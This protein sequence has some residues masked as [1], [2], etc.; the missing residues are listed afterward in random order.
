MHRRF[1]RLTS[2]TAAIDMKCWRFVSA[3]AGSPKPPSCGHASSSRGSKERAEPADGEQTPEK[4]CG[5]PGEEADSV[6]SSVQDNRLLAGVAEH[7]HSSCQIRFPP[8]LEG[9]P[10][11]LAPLWPRSVPF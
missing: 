11:Q 8:V 6:R 3:P 10:R 5:A 4:C 7:E 2:L 9:S 1:P